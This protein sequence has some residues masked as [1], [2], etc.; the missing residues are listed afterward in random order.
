MIPTEP[1]VIETLPDPLNQ[2]NLNN[3]HVKSQPHP[4][5]SQQQQSRPSSLVFADDEPLPSGYGIVSRDVNPRDMEGWTEV[6]EEWKRISTRPKNLT[7]LVK[8][9]IP[10]ALRGE[11]WQLLAGCPP[12]SNQELASTYAS[13]LSKECPDEVYVKRDIGRTF[14]AHDYFRETE[15][16]GQEALYRVL[17]AYAVY[18]EEVGY[19]QGFSFIAA[20]LLLHMPEEQAF[21]VL[22]KIMSDYGLRFALKD[23]FETL[24]L[25]F[26]QLD[27][28]IEDHLSDL[29][30]HFST[31]HIESHM[32]ASQWFLTLF[33]AKFPL[34]VV[35]YILD[36]YLLEGTPVLFQVSLS[37]LQ[38]SK[39]D[40]VKL[41]FEGILKYFRIQ[42]PKN[43]TSEE[44][45]K[46]LMQ[47]ACSKRVKNQLTSYEK[48]YHAIREADRQ[49]GNTIK[50]MQ[51]ENKRLVYSNMRLEQENDDLARELICSK[52]N[53]RKQLDE[54][55]DKN[56]NLIK[57][58]NQSQMF[59]REL[60]EERK[61]LLEEVNQLKEVCR[62]E[63][64]SSEKE[65]TRQSSIISDYKSICSQLSHRLE[66]MQSCHQQ[67][68]D[69]ILQSIRSC[70]TCHQKAS[71]VANDQLVNG[72]VNGSVSSSQNQSLDSTILPSSPSTSSNDEESLDKRVREL[73]LELAQTKLAL[74]EAECI[75]Q[76]LVHEARELRE[77][78]VASQQHHSKPTW[79]HKTL[80]T[81]R[82]ARHAVKERSQQHQQPTTPTT[83]TSV[84]SRNSVS[85]SNSKD[86][87]S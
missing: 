23:G 75:N 2:N 24:Y 87:G 58:V 9:G 4:H 53:L 57:E 85:R 67:K 52:I 77:Q 73:E 31:Q 16:V 37:L 50:L 79:I 28:L 83:S 66:K 20:A 6:L 72:G 43:Y 74:V 62:R 86:F 1:T 10:D 44:N 12:E 71:L 84:S 59:I 76:D 13:L 54:L 19:C 47:L 61:R 17:K 46:I 5:P 82:E 51:K 14:P 32:Y 27:R 69:R 21:S 70:E 49:K 25:R 39:D 18:D 48:A 65:I 64:V 35:F 11:V 7:D 68:I 60:E 36:I 30:K 81:I 56:D 63:V 42:L 34:Y 29:W 8:K 41:D 38:L 40:L 55:E 80:T 78:I 33:T 3:N 26:Y 45:A 15:S 22:V